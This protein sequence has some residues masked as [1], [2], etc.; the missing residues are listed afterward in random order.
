MINIFHQQVEDDLNE[1]TTAIDY[2]N[3]MA[4]DI[5]IK[6]GILVKYDVKVSFELGKGEYNNL[7]V[8]L[9]VTDW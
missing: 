6:H 4:K 2:A 7:I 5:K 8:K 9:S 1:L 3:D